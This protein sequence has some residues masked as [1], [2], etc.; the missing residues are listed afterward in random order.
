MPPSVLPSMPRGCGRSRKQGG[1]YAV[2]PTSPY[3]TPLEDF[4]WCPPKLLN[5]DIA[6]RGQ[7]PVVHLGT[8]HLI[9]WIGAQHYPNVADWIEETRVGGISRIINWRSLELDRLT[10]DSRLIVVHPRAHIH[11]LSEYGPV[12]WPCPRRVVEHVAHVGLPAPEMCA[13]AY[14]WDVEGGEVLEPASQDGTEQHGAGP[15]VRRVMPAFTYIGHAR[16]PHVDPVYSPAMF[17]AFPIARLEVVRGEH[18]E[19]EPAVER[20]SALNLNLDWEV[21]DG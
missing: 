15:L 16:P 9:D 7:T 14:W 10:A 21:V 4:L 3:G 11:N 6:P 1:V 5:F 20:L 13:G 19:H 12:F 17:G 2:T 18:G 8:Y